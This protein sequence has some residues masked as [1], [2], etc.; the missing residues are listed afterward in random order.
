MP[1]RSDSDAR[2]GRMLTIRDVAARLQVSDKTVSR[3]IQHGELTA[4]QLGRQWR[5]AEKDL[6]AFIRAARN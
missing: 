3:W 1:S 6:E 2:S 4:Y 5:I